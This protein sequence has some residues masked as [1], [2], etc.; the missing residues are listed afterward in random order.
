[1]QVAYEIGQLGIH[2]TVAQS[3]G[4]FRFCNL[5]ELRYF[6]K[7]LAVSDG[8]SIST[9]LWNEAKRRTLEVYAESKCLEIMRHFFE[10]FE[11]IHKVYYRSDLREFIMESNL[12]DFIAV[13]GRS[14]FVSTIHKAKG[15]E[16]DTVYLMSPVPG[17]MEVE[18][19]RAYYVGLTRA[20]RNLYLLQQPASQS[21]S[22]SVALNLHDVWLDY[23][24]P[25]K[26]TVLQLR[27]GDPLVYRDGLFMNSQGLSVAALSVTG[28]EKLKAWEDKGYE[29]VSAEVSFVVA[30]WSKEDDK[31]YAVCLPDVVLKNKQKQ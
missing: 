21:A 31:D 17:A 22:V 13:D 25:R 26:A 11:A 19:M 10:D 12:E 30:W 5:A 24:K 7:Q 14:I 3:M 9:E 23:F 20:K 18:Q 15:R 2:A 6:M 28:K 16:F 4:G 29:V 27:S 1:M 8:I